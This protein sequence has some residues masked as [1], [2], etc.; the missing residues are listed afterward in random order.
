M[1][2]T[3]AGMA[4]PNS[5]Q[6]LGLWN[7]EMLCIFMTKIAVLEESKNLYLGIGENY[8]VIFWNR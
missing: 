3:I 2:Q 8:Q 5:K 4:D 1:K 7:I 6:M